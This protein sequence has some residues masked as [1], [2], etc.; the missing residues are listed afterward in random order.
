MEIKIVNASGVTVFN[1]IPAFDTFRGLV[2][3]GQKIQ[4]IKFMREKDPCWGLKEAKDFVEACDFPTVV[5]DTTTENFL[6][7]IKDDIR[8]IILDKSDYRETLLLDL[9]ARVAARV[10]VR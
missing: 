7:D 6:S 2:A 3:S 4:A 5:S 1:N 8:S 9:F 10:G